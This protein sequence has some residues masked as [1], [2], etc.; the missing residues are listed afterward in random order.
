MGARRGLAGNEALSKPAEEQMT[1]AAKADSAS[2]ELG[3]AVPRVGRPLSRKL[4]RPDYA[5]K[6]KIQSF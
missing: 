2:D 3:H 4:R 5:V 1:S 6:I